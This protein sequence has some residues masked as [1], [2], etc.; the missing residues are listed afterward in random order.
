MFEDYII[1]AVVPTIRCDSLF[2]IVYKYAKNNKKNNP[3]TNKRA[4]PNSD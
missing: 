1:L 2:K 3:K 4:T